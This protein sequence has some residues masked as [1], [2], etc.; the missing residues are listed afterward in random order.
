MELCSGA[1]G[2]SR[3]SGCEEVFVCPELTWFSTLP[4][5][6]LKAVPAPCRPCSL[7]QTLLEAGQSHLQ[8]IYLDIAQC[9]GL[10]A[11]HISPSE[12]AEILLRYFKSS[13][14]HINNI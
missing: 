11:S 12:P 8:H 7:S 4:A 6:H 3:M 9:G 13:L 14:C 2:N 1:Q 5:G 10:Q